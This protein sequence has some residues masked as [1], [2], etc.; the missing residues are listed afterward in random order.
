MNVNF[1]KESSDSLSSESDETSSLSSDINDDERNELRGILG[2]LY[3]FHNNG[4][5]VGSAERIKINVVDD[6][7]IISVVNVD[8]YECT[9]K[10]IKCKIISPCCGKAFSCNRCHDEYYDN[11]KNSHVI[12]RI[13][14]SRIVCMKCR[15][16]QDISNHCVKCNNSFAEYYCSICKVFDNNYGNYHC[17]K[18][19]ICIVGNENNFTHCDTCQ[20]CIEKDHLLSH[21]CL[22]DILG[23]LCSVC[24]DSLKN[25]ENLFLVKCGHALHQ[26]CYNSLI[27][28][29]YKCP[30]CFKTIKD[31]KQ[32][33]LFLDYDIKNQPMSEVK[34]IKIMCNDC[35]KTSIANFHYLGT[36]C[37]NCESYNTYEQ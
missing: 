12:D 15:E 19:K 10:N 31:T 6:T 30:T 4:L 27:E 37:K 16:Y 25:G 7:K 26:D 34:I 11:K 5:S 28:T 23:R 9:H 3:H 36:K 29:S 18:C 2:E 17:N 8:E 20:C 32:Q 14:I 21:K 1:G 22:P 33:F 13:K 35:E 24:M